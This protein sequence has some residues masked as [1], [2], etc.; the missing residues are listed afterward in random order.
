MPGSDESGHR[1]DGAGEAE[2]KPNRQR[3]VRWRGTVLYPSLLVALFLG[4]QGALGLVGVSPQHQAALAAVPAVT[5][6]LLSLPP[7]LRLV[8]GST[9]PWRD[10]GVAVATPLVAQALLRGLSKAILL[11][12][13]VTV[14]LALAAQLRWQPRLTVGLVWNA[15][16]L[17]LGVG[18]AEELLFRGWLQGEL[19]LLLGPQRA[20][21][22]QAALFSLVHC[23]F[24]LPG[25]LL[26]SLLAGLLLLGLVLGLQRRGD[27]GLLWGAIGL[28]SGLVGGWFLINQGLVEISAQT[29]GWLIGPANPVGSLPGCLGL[30]LLLVAQRRWL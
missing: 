23:R 27:G 10:L 2:L 19:T 20:L 8:W 26:L 21:W 12:V 24:D 4:S 5:A 28:H 6:L 25:R 17:G 1:I 22:L 18:C 29:P 13:L 9:M 16:L 11:L 30:G 14:C 7:R 15:V 3:S